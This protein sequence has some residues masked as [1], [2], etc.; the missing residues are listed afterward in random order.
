MKGKSRALKALESVER[1]A[2]NADAHCMAIFRATSTRAQ[3]RAGD[4]YDKSMERMRQK[5]GDLR[6]II[7]E[8]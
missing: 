8:A 3:E 2:G 7:T 5:L 6:K 4:K 1:F